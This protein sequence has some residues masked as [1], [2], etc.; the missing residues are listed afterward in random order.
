MTSLSTVCVDQFSML[1]GAVRKEI[2]LTLEVIRRIDAAKSV[3]AGI[4]AEAAR[5]SEIKGLTAASLRRK[6]YAVK[7][8]GWQALINKAAGL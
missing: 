1:P 2:E 8:H 4:S 7:K 6:Y 5:C 3:S